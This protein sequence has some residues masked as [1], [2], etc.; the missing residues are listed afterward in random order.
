MALQKDGRG[1]YDDVGQRYPPNQN[2]IQYNS[3]NREYKV[4]G[5]VRGDAPVDVFYYW[6]LP[7]EFI[8]NQVCN[9]LYAEIGFILSVTPR[10]FSTNEKESIICLYV[11]D[12]YSNLYMHLQR[13]AF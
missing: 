1:N 11:L 6:S 12:H 2:A 7:P 13:S 8:G 3:A 5:H 10:Y 4:E 9:L